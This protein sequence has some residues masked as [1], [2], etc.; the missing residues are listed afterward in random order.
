MSVKRNYKTEDIFFEVVVR[1]DCEGA[2]SGKRIIIR[3]K[4]NDKWQTIS[5]IVPKEIVKGKFTDGSLAKTIFK[6]FIKD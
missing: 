6:F 1:D 3:I 4:E 2:F 5:S